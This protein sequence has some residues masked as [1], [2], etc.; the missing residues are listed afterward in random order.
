MNPVVIVGG[1]WAGLA[2]AVELTGAGVPAQLLESA[3]QLGG[4]ARSVVLDGLAVDNGQHLLIGA[5]RETLRLMRQLG[6]NPELLRRESLQLSVRRDAELLQLSTP[7]LPAPLHLAW[8]LWHAAG[9]RPGERRAALRFCLRAWRQRFSVTPD[10]SVA[11]LLADQPP[12]LVRALWEPLCLA[13]LNT[14]PAQASARVFLRVLRDAFARRRHDADLIHPCADLGRLLPEPARCHI[15]RQGGMVST[16]QRVDALTLA[17]D[18]FGVLTRDGLQ[19]ASH[20][21]LATAPWHAAPLLAAHPTLEP[22]ARQLAAL[23]SAPITT[24]YLAYPPGVTLGRAM[25]GISTGTG[26]WL[27]DRGVLCGQHGLMAAVISG[28]GAHE[29]LEAVQLTAQISGEIAAHFPHWPAATTIRVVR[30]RRATFLCDVGVDARRPDNATPLPRLWLA[31]DYTDT[32]YP[33]TLEGAVRSG[34]QCARRIIN[35]LR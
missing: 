14:P 12:A 10:I 9:L 19:P 35:L 16:R 1:G 7:P 6:T 27:I 29:T 31:G 17:D 28:P 34:V 24:V 3:P 4:R 32:G 13:T 2:A 18:A 25:L 15:E 21:V 22:L 30:E 5:Y 33:A 11:D 23:G 8:A 26:L 20:I